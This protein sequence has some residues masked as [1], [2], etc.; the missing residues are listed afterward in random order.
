MALFHDYKYGETVER[1]EGCEVGERNESLI[2]SSLIY[3]RESDFGAL[4]EQ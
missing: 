3:P 4:W 1:G 2:I